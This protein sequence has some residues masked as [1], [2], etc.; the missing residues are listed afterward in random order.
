MKHT[1]LALLCLAYCASLYAPRLD[2]AK[3]KQLLEG[4]KNIAHQVVI[5]AGPAGLAAAI[6]C[7][8]SGYHTVIFQGP[9]PGGE[10][11]DSQTVENWPGVPATS[12]AL[13]MHKLE[14]Q[15][16][17]F[18]AH[19]APQTVTEVDLSTWPI[20][21]TL[22]DGS[23]V[24]ALTVTIATGAS[25]K[26]LGIKGEDEYF[27]NGLFSCG[28]CDGSYTT[29]KDTIVIGG[30]DIA[31][32]RVLQLAPKA[33]SVTLIVASE[34]PTATKSL[35]K[36]VNDL[37][38]VKI[39]TNKMV[40][41]ICGNGESITH[42]EL[43]DTVTREK[44]TL[45]TSSVFLSTGMTPNTDLIKNKL[46]CDD[47]GCIK[48]KDRTQETAIEGVFAC[49]TCADCRYRQVAVVIGDGTKAGLDTLRILSRWGFDG[50]LRKK[51]L[52]RLYKPTT[53]Q[54]PAIQLIK[55]VKEFKR[56]IRN[57][58][59]PVLVEFYSPSCPSCRK[60]EA[61][62]SN[63]A[64][65]FKEVLK[66]L[67]VN[68]D[69]LSELGKDHDID[70]IPAFIIYLNGRPENRMEGEMTLDELS[71]FIENTCDITLDDKSR[72]GFP[73]SM[74]CLSEESSLA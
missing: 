18:G 1:S 49:G 39:L 36:K 64:E 60:M 47:A 58:S 45:K 30:A 19:I 69:K 27:G 50:P 12:G 54:S 29:G 20:K 6:P 22:D 32:Q 66:V 57:A 21:V 68:N 59:L 51:T 53:I 2:E 5:G 4:K 16:M 48:L 52:D 35:L 40:T 17:G 71:T 26:M 67:K 46:E 42:I 62:L 63:V 44:S 25:Q 43:I 41:A 9:K 23:Y 13:S 11:M 10:L 3:I 24:N 74:T 15:V 14:K 28:I 56:A 37:K 73:Y 7:A 72:R 33:R 70:I 65:R 8:R 34:C 31:M 38:N 55:T 61:P